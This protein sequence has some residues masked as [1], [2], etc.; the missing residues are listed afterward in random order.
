MNSLNFSTFLDLLRL[1]LF[2]RLLAILVFRHT[3]N[4]PI[5]GTTF[6]L[7]FADFRDSTDSSVCR[8]DRHEV[9]EFSEWGNLRCFNRVRLGTARTFSVSHWR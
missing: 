2:A 5:S 6:R 3:E 4:R 9:T 7:T 1:V 8:D